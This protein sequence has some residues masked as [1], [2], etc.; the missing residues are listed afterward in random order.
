MQETAM[1]QVLR[2]EEVL[3]AFINAET[4]E[5]ASAILAENGIEISPQELIEAVS[6][7]ENGGSDELSEDALDDVAGGSVMPVGRNIIYAGKLI[8]AAYSNPKV[9]KASLGVIGTLWK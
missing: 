6:L 4:A 8:Q 2:N 9:R 3:N 1:E 7:E 5:L